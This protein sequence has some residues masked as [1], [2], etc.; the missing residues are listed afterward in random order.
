M[1]MRLRWTDRSARRVCDKSPCRSEGDLP[2]ETRRGELV[3]DTAPVVSFGAG[4][5]ASVRGGRTEIHDR[6]GKH[7]GTLYDTYDAIT[8]ADGNLHLHTPKPVGPH[9]TSDE[10]S[11]RWT[12][13]RS[14]VSLNKANENFYRRIS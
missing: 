10:Q 8:D 2:I 11:N 7:I 13:S 14:L 3:K 5:V 4:H 9:S 12:H 1:I 6:T